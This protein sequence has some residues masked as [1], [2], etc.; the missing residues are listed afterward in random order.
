MAG[1]F[2]TPLDNS[3][4][5]FINSQPPTREGI[6]GK[7]GENDSDNGNSE[8]K[9]ASQFNTRGSTPLSPAIDKL[10]LGRF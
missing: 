9:I 1:V 4:F 7:T 8:K 6:S 5:M 3:L 10:I 2:L